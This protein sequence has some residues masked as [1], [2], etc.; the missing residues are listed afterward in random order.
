MKKILSRIILSIIA[1]GL[2]FFAT[3]IWAYTQAPSFNDNF[4]NYLTDNTPDEYGRVETVFNLPIDK[5]KTLMENVRCL[6][7]PNPSMYP[8]CD[9]ASAGGFLW[10]VIRY[11]GFIILFAYIVMV[12]INLMLYPKDAEKVK[13]NLKSLMYI[14][15]GGFV[16]LGSTRIL[17]TVL[18]VGA[19]QGSGALVDK[20]QGGPNSLFFQILSFLKILTF[21]LAIIMMVILGFRIMSAHDAEKSKKVAKSIMNIILALILV[22]TIDFFYYIAQSPQFAEKSA[23][24]IIDIARVLA[25]VMGGAL[26]IMIFYAGFLTVT[27]QGKEENFTKAKNIIVSVL[28]GGGVLF[29]F[30]LILYQIFSEFA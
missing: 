29:L 14:G 15:Y 25:Y 26:M 4:A 30:L 21:F 27:D 6:L 1:L 24:F 17:G 11:A 12:G 16:L 5:N 8:G 20:I 2:G 7:Y 28:L 18:N 10:D 13:N 19:I 22:K 9:T 23:S 3:E